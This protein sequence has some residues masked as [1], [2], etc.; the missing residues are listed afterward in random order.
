MLTPLE[1]AQASHTAS[2][3]LGQR[4]V[5]K[6]AD[7]KFH[8]FLDLDLIQRFFIDSQARD[9][10]GS[11]LDDT[12]L[13]LRAS[14]EYF[15]LTGLLDVRWSSL[16]I[17]SAGSRLDVGPFGGG[18][19]S[20]AYRYLSEGPPRSLWLNQLRSEDETMHQIGIRP[21]WTFF[22]ALTLRYAFDLAVDSLELI[23]QSWGLRYDSPC[24]CWSADLNVLHRP[25]MNAP[26]VIITFDFAS[27]GEG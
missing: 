13:R 23:E 20:A 12:S 2:L 8:R 1:A 19:L 17:G 3:T 10:F 16:S 14:H 11:V 24:R 7:G 9:R 22:K 4:L 6:D 21:S 18:R 26:D 25:G 5:L 27:L 15:S